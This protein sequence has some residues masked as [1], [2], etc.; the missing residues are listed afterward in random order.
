VNGELH[1]KKNKIGIFYNSLKPFK[2]YEELL[3]ENL[4]KS[5]IEI[6]NIYTSQMRIDD[7]RF[8]SIITNWLSRKIHLI[9]HN[10]LIWKGRESSINFKLRAY[11]QFGSKKD[12]M[13]YSNYIGFYVH[14]YSH[15]EKI[16]VKLFA[17]KYFTLL[18]KLVLTL[19]IFPI[20]EKLQKIDIR[21][22]KLI[23]IPYG[24]RMSIEEDFIIWLARKYNIKTLGIQENWDNLSS[25]KFIFQKTDYFVTW[26]SQSSLHLR[27]IQGFKG[28][29]FEFGC[30]RMQQFYEFQN[31]SLKDPSHAK[32]TLTS[33][34]KVIL[35][36]GNGSQN[37]VLLLDFFERYLSQFNDLKKFDSIIFR[38]H[39]QSRIDL[40]HSVS[41]KNDLIKIIP[42]KK[43]EMNNYRLSLIK[44]SSLIIGFYSTVILES[45]IMDKVVAIP[46]FL[47]NAFHYK[48]YRF[49]NDSAHFNPLSRIINLHNFRYEKDF[50]D[51]LNKEVPYSK[52]FDRERILNSCC[53]NKDTITEIN[54]KVQQFCS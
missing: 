12:K 50:I 13:K 44:D 6:E 9:L 19:L 46:S 18:L 53:A 30:M 17:F 7:T 14:P 21:S 42:P 4:R 33:R 36:I 39:P 27:N 54:L 51:F 45:L 29:I 38:P 49:L 11:C 22:L 47:G 40:G 25:K 28:E 20:M 16:I 2:E 35:V 3:N 41:I 48:P 43:N 8:N 1:S 37:D 26:G 23:L 15:F 5:D 31:E 32:T 10:S 34:E 24:A 52:D